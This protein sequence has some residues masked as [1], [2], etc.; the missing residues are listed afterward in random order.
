MN[1][2]VFVGPV[3]VFG[4]VVSNKWYGETM[5]ISESKARSNLE[6]QFKKEANLIA[7]SRIELIGEVKIK[8]TVS[9][10]K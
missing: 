8:N 6:Y 2:Y 9:G 5:S 7:G 3:T 10:G 1:R 4:K